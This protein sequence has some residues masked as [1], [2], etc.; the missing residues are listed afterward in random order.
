MI[1]GCM[2]AKDVLLAED[3]LDDLLHF[4]IAIK[5][6]EIPVVLRHAK[7]GEVLFALLK[8]AIPD[9]LFLDIHMPCRNGVSCIMEI[10]QNRMYDNM[11]VIILTSH[12]HQSY[13]DLTYRTGAN[14]YLIKPNTVYDLVEKL[15]MIFSVDWE[16]SMYYPPKSEYLIA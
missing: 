11:P 16:K 5:G 1:T 9:I 15:K 8:E 10:R 2:R 14:F 12:K 6:I 7:D 3:D 4:Q 13:V